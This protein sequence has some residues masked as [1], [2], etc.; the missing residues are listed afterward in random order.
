MY[1]RAGD[2]RRALEDANRAVEARSD[3]VGSRIE[4][5]K[6]LRALNDKAGVE[7]RCDALAALDLDEP[8]PL[9]RRAESLGWSCHRWEQSLELT[10]RVVEQYPNWYGAYGDR[11]TTNFFLGRFEE[12]IADLTRA[13]ELNPYHHRSYNNRGEALGRLH[14]HEEAIA[15][16]EK[17]VELAPREEMQRS[18]LG[19][20]KLRLGRVDE[21][22]ADFEKAIELDPFYASAHVSRGEILAIRGDCHGA[23]E[24]L[25]RALELGA[26]DWQSQSE[27]SAAYTGT[28]YYFCPEQHDAAAALDLARGVLD[29]TPD[30]SRVVAR[31]GAALLGIEP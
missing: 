4:Q 21:A 1:A 27:L 14:R 26:T 25:N 16:F 7:A 29:Q 24:E 28:L 10:D 22:L 3:D 23:I 2:H 19:L 11:G 31:Y 9:R 8:G 30:D 18:N 13:I 17:A 20:G 15:D 12:A 6:A 5:I